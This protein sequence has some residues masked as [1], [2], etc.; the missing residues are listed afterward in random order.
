[1]SSAAKAKGSGAERDVV[2]YLKEWFP[3]VDRRLAGATL[4]QTC[5]FIYN[6]Y[7]LQ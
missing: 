6:S 3:Y 5:R 1:M 4:A 7:H 2:K